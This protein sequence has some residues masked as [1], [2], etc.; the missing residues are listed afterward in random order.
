MID[1][2]GLNETIS[3]DGHV[4]DLPEILRSAGLFVLSSRYEGFPMVLLEAMSCALPVVAFDC[5]TGPS[6]LIGD[7]VTGR[8]VPAGETAELA[9]AISSL[10]EQP[11]HR[12][13]F[14]QAAA[15][16][17]QTYDRDLI[18]TRWENLFQRLHHTHENRRRPPSALATSP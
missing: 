7:C 3:L 16:H 2:Q 17:A 5:P 13:R 11:S 14:G 18:A 10:I 12:T 1:A 6:E 15:L 9:A 4:D 8:L